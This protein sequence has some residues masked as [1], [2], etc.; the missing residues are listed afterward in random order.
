MLES[1]RA[2]LYSLYLR[3]ARQF[4][5]IVCNLEAR[6]RGFMLQEIH[7]KEMKFASWLAKRIL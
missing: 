6:V 4:L 3:F 2:E 1:P 5:L 7:G